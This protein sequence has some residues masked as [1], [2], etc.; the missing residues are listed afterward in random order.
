M[1]KSTEKDLKKVT[2]TAQEYLESLK[3]KVSK[4]TTVKVVVKEV[5][6][7]EIVESFANKNIL[8]LNNSVSSELSDDGSTDFGQNLF[9]NFD[10][11]VWV[12]DG[13]INIKDNTLD[14]EIETVTSFDCFIFYGT[15]SYKLNKFY[16]DLYRSKGRNAVLSDVSSYDEM[17]DEDKETVARSWGDFSGVNISRGNFDAEGLGSFLDDKD[18]RTVVKKQQVLLGVQSGTN[19]TFIM[20]CSGSTINFYNE[21]CKKVKSLGFY[22]SKFETKL[23]V[24]PQHYLLADGTQSKYKIKPVNFTM[25]CSIATSGIKNGDANNDSIV[26]IQEKFMSQYVNTFFKNIITDI[27]SVS[28]TSNTETYIDVTDETMENI[29]LIASSEVL[30]D[31]DIPF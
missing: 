6:T 27:R 11:S 28:F 2:M 3:N 31:E 12:A 24:V 10:L 30:N 8:P 21:Y 7:D 1:A 15:K 14:T 20:F 26:D 19:K 29:P 25:N 9:K 4:T 5:K 18:L 23:K 22:I 13:V 16:A 17:T